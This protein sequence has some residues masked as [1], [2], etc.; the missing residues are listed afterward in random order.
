MRFDYLNNLAPTVP[1]R[2]DQ[3]SFQPP[4]AFSSP[5]YLTENTLCWIISKRRKI[6]LY[7]GN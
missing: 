2:P 7:T 3:V 4:R 5:F 1:L 6:Y